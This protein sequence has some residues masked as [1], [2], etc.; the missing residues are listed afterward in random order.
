LWQAAAHF[1]DHRKRERLMILLVKSSISVNSPFFYSP[2]TWPD[3]AKAPVPGTEKRKSLPSA[4]SIF[5]HEKRQEAR[6]STADKAFFLLKVG[7]LVTKSVKR[8][9]SRMQTRHLF[10]SLK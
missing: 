7:F 1:Q 10:F 9:G 3:F 8:P 2:Q 6:E 4:L 5:F